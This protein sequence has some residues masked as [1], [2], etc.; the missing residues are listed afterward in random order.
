MFFRTLVRMTSV[1]S[2]GNGPVGVHAHDHA[3]AGFLAVRRRAETHRTS[4]GHDDVSAFLNEGFGEGAAVIER[5]K[6]TGEGAIAS[7]GAPAEHFHVGAHSLVVVVHTGFETDHEVSNTVGMLI[8]PKVA[9]L[10]VLVERSGG[11]TSQEASLIRGEGQT[12][13]VGQFDAEPQSWPSTK[14]GQQSG[15]HSPR[16]R[17]LDRGWLSRQPGWNPRRAGSR[18]SRSGR[19]PHQELL[20]VLVVVSLLVDS[21]YLPSTPNSAISLLNTCVRSGIEGLVID[22]AEVGHLP[23]LSAPLPPHRR[24]RQRERQ[25]SH[26]QRMCSSPHYKIELLHVMFLLTFV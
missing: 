11:V 20:D 19:F 12:E 8:P 15:R 3:G 17:K 13:H 9:T 23:T 2:G 18:R 4:H 24:H 16:W 10:P 26:D 1:Y 5:L 14:P 21:R 25:R 6:V 7:C 22:T